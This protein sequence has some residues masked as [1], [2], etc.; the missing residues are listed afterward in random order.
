M[1]CRAICI[2]R[3]TGAHGEVV[4]QEVAERLGFQYVDEEVISEAAEWADLDPALVAGVERK[5]S[6]VDRLLG[7]AGEPGSAPQLPTSAAG[8]RTLPSDAELRQMITAA[9]ASFVKRGSVVIVAHAASFAVGGGDVLRVLVTASA[10]TRAERIMAERGLDG[11]EAERAIKASD[12][13]R[14]NYLKRFYGV[15]QELPTHYDVVVNTDVL[16]AADAAS[17]IAAAS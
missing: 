10:K 12:A 2:S 9:I 14:A 1:A 17:I 4:G 5:K 15:D 3:A 6:F 13:G 7:T 16:T 8:T 11:R